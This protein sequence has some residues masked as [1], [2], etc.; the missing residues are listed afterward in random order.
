MFKNKLLKHHFAV[1]IMNVCT[2]LSILTDF[3]SFWLYVK[4]CSFVNNTCKI[5]LLK[6]IELIENLN[7]LR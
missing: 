6:L 1:K 2:P 3:R 4:E 5:V 7:F